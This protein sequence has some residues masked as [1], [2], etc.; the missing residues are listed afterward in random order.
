MRLPD[1]PRNAALHAGGLVELHARQAGAHG[2]GRLGAAGFLLA[3]V[4]TVALAPL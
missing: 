3:F 1:R 4:A 2:Y